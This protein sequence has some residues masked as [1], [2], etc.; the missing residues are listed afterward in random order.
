[1]GGTLK[2]I[3]KY[4]TMQQAQQPTQTQAQPKGHLARKL[5][6]VKAVKTST[7]VTQN[8]DTLG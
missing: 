8:R 5:A 1:M 4:Q 7:P 6:S 3:Q 2:K